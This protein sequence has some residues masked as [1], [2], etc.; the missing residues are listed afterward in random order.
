MRQGVCFYL[1]RL[2]PAVRWMTPLA[3]DFVFLFLK[4]FVEYVKATKDKPVLILLDNHD[5]HLSI[6]SLD[7]DNENESVLS[8]PPRCSHRL[9]PMD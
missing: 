1:V 2:G 4:H 3:A 5:S 8:F 7:Y 6:N 9:Q